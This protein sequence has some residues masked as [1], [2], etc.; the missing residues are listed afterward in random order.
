MSSGVSLVWL[1][2]GAENAIA[3]SEGRTGVGPP[4]SDTRSLVN[5]RAKSAV[6]VRT[7]AIAT[8]DAVIL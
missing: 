6:P 4:P 8:A 5:A 3:L 2:T 7:I 1:P